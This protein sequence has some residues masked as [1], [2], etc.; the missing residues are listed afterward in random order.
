MTQLPGVMYKN[1][2]EAFEP[3]KI[4]IEVGENK[5]YTVDFDTKEKDFTFTEMN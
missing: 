5:K 2:M 1:V 3:E 4:E